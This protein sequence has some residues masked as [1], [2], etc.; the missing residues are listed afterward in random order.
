MDPGLVYGTWALVGVTGLFAW[1]EIVN[2]QDAERVR[3]TVNR[4]DRYESEEMQRYRRAL[5]EQL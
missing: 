4:R 2:Q 3:M 1:R 5:A